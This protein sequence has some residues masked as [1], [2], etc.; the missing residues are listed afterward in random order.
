MYAY[1]WIHRLKDLKYFQTLVNITTV[2]SRYPDTR[3]SCHSANHK[4]SAFSKSRFFVHD[5]NVNELWIL[6]H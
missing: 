6:L 4:A 3:F 5:F 2:E 1:L